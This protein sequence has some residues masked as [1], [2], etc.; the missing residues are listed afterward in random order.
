MNEAF[1]QGGTDPGPLRRPGVL[2]WPTGPHEREGPPI[3]GPS[4][5]SV[6]PTPPPDVGALEPCG[7][8]FVAQDLPLRSARLLVGRAQE[9][10]APQIPL[11]RPFPQAGTDGSVTQVPLHRVVQQLERAVLP[12]P[13]SCSAR[14]PCLGHVEHWL[15]SLSPPPMSDGS[16]LQRGAE[17]WPDTPNPGF[18]GPDTGQ[19][20]SGTENGAVKM[21]GCGPYVGRRSPE[22][23]MSRARELPTGS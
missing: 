15:S 6:C 21:S 12:R 23:R 1:R 4:L 10:P 13:V 18:L 5:V 19:I 20:R 22:S 8:L 9:Q 16:H 3:G 14:G 17:Q 2:L 7:F 11:R